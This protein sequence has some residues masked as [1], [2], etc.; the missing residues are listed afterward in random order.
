MGHQKQK[1]VLRRVLQYRELP[2]FVCNHVGKRVKQMEAKGMDRR[3]R[4]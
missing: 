1:Q 2:S 3:R 4:S